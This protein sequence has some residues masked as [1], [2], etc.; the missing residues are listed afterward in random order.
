MRRGRKDRLSSARDQ[1][2]ALLKRVEGR[3]TAIV[4]VMSARAVPQTPSSPAAAWATK[5]REGEKERPDIQKEKG[6]SM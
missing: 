6:E 1:S 5:K 4:I 3:G 2:K